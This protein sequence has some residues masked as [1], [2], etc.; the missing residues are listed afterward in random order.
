MTCDIVGHTQAEAFHSDCCSGVGQQ[1]VRF[2]LPGSSVCFHGDSATA[3]LLQ[4]RDLELQAR[5]SHD[6]G[7]QLGA[8][9]LEYVCQSR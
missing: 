1:N 2:P 5:M 9:L 3:P 6:P 8:H 7:L 4:R